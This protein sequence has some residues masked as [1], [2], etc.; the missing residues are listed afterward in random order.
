MRLTWGEGAEHNEHRFDGEHACEAK[1][2]L[3]IDLIAPA[4]WDKGA[5]SAK[6][7]WLLTGEALDPATPSLILAALPAPE[8]LESATPVLVHELPNGLGLTAPCYVVMLSPRQ[9]A[10]FDLTMTVT[11]GKESDQATARIRSLPEG[12]LTESPQ[13]KLERMLRTLDIDGLRA[14]LVPPATD[15]MAHG[16]DAGRDGEAEPEPAEDETSDET[17]GEAE[18]R[19][20]FEWVHSETGENLLLTLLARDDASSAQRSEI[21]HL[22]LAAGAALPTTAD[23]AG[24][25][26][27]AAPSPLHFVVHRRELEI[28]RELLDR[29]GAFPAHCLCLWHGRRCTTPLHLACANGDLQMALLLLQRGAHAD[30]AGLTGRAGSVTPL[31]L[32]IESGCVELAR[33]LIVE[34]GADIRLRTLDPA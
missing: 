13:E 30:W 8:W 6:A 19:P 15:A 10:L 21:F 34:K 14:L 25:R 23:A 28:A 32:A 1:V 29:P 27:D 20:A 18:E 24:M 9:P 5:V 4:L 3:Y 22:L 2:T 33:I 7:K 26:G 11:L 31:A 17:A 12:G 16:R